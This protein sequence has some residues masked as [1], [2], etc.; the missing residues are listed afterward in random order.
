MTITAKGI[1]TNSP[2][3][4]ATARGCCIAVP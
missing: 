1:C 2:E 4:M 3:M